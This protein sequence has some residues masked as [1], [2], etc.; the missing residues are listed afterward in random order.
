MDF[1]TAIDKERLNAKYYHAKG[2][3]FQAE[4][5]SMQKDPDHSIEEVEEKTNSA[6]A[7][8][9]MALQYCD[10]FISPM[11]HQGLMFH[12]TK[13]YHEALRMFSKVEELLPGDR[14]VYIE[15]G[16]VYQNMGNHNYAIQ[17]FE[18][19]IKID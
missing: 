5:E 4:V 12:R 10:T 15:R 18:Q 2:L 17:D 8:F 9:G 16:L 11:F 14:S 1:D 13:R 3:A 7:F 19:A 6:I